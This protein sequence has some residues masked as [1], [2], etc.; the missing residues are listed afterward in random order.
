MASRF[1][2]QSRFF[3]RSMPQV[4]PFMR[5]RRKVSWDSSAAAAAAASS[6]VLFTMVASTTASFLGPNT[7]NHPRPHSP[8]KDTTPSPLVTFIT[9]QRRWS[10]MT[11][12]SL[13]RVSCEEAISEGENHLEK[14]EILDNDSATTANSIKKDDEGSYYYERMKP[15]PR[16]MA[17]SHAIFGPLMGNTYI[18]RYH[19]YRRVSLLSGQDED[20]RRTK[21]QVKEQGP[22]EVAVADI[23]IGSQLNGHD[24]IVHGGI[25]SLLFDDAMGWGYDALVQQQRQQQ[26][27]QEEDNHIVVTANLT[28][29]YRSPLY[30]KTSAI[31][32]I[33]HDKTDGRKVYFRARL[34]SPDGQTLY[35]EATSLY[36]KV[37]PKS[38]PKNDA[39]Q[40]GTST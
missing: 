35:S 26:Q 31:M 36:I 17:E 4:A 18:E 32:R 34:E 40:M 27:Q 30:S 1:V 9:S 10:E 29:N 15:P 37:R 12:G 21:D 23:H 14:E 7:Y 13:N 8:T 19:V 20:D 5:H 22:V 28:V 6:L 3:S 16:S 39:T 11:H 24:G 25:A 2:V 38:S 33:Y